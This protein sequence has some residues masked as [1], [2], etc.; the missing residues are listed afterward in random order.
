MLPASFVRRRSHRGYGSRVR[1][2]TDNTDR[3]R[4]FNRANLAPFLAEVSTEGERLRTASCLCKV[5]LVSA[6]HYH[7]MTLPC[8]RY[9]RSSPSGQWKQRVSRSDSLVRFRVL[10]VAVPL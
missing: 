4:F 3:T 7:E 9:A 6:A 8:S 1:N 2:D 5:A 10:V